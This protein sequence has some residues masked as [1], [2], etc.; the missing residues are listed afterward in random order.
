MLFHCEVVGKAVNDCVCVYAWADCC[1]EGGLVTE[2][3]DMASMV[4]EV[5]GVNGG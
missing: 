5:D 3:D 2:V 1:G 4:A